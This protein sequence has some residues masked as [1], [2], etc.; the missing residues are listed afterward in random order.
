M[1]ANVEAQK[2]I[3]PTDRLYWEDLAVGQT[4][5]FGNCYISRKDITDFA[6]QF[7]PQPFH[8]DEQAARATM[9]KGLAASGWHICTVFMR[10]LEDGLLSRCQ[11]SQLD[12]IDKIKWRVP[13]RPGDWLSCRITIEAKNPLSKK[14]GGGDCRLECAA[15]NGRGHTVMSWQVRLTLAHRNETT[16]AGAGE[17]YAPT[18]ELVN[19]RNAVEGIR[20]FEDVLPGDEIALGAHVFSAEE[21]LDFHACYCVPP[22]HPDAV[23]TRLSASGWHVT[24]IWM[25]RL[26]RYYMREAVK[27]RARGNGVPQLGPSPGISDLR[28]HR[29]VYVGDSLAF[30]CRANRKLQLPRQPGWGL[31]FAQTDIRNADDDSVATFTVALFLERRSK[32]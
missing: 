19:R 21:I 32:V 14:A 26:V 22:I 30:A 25:Q 15:I 10:M 4:L 29:P 2:S 20:Y 18:V 12:T 13:V 1:T 9:L 28:W 11:G 27:L 24:A 23:P 5:N 17:A 31:L 7:D 6:R 8:I 16:D 3:P